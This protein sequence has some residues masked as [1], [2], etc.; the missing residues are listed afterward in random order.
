MKAKRASIAALALLVASAA[1]SGSAQ[2]FAQTC[3]QVDP[4]T[5][6]TIVVIGDTQD[7]ADYE[8]KEN[9]QF[10][11]APWL[12]SMI[13]WILANRQA[14]NIDFVLQVGDLTE[15]GWWLP[16]SPTCLGDCG[17]PGCHCPAE[18]AEEWN[19]ITTQFQ[20]L[21]SAHVPFALVPGNHDNIR[22]GGGPLDGPGFSDYYAPSRLAGLSGYLESKTSAASGCTATAWQ[23]ALG[24]EPVIVLALP[25]SDVNPP[26]ETRPDG[27]QAVA[28]CPAVD[29][30]IDDWAN[31]LIER[32][33]HVRKQA[34]LLHHRLIDE[35][36]GLRP[37]WVN[38]ISRRPERY[39][40]GISGHFS[41]AVFPFSPEV[42]SQTG[43]D[44]WVFAPRIDWQDVPLPGL[45]QPT[46]ASTFAVLRFHVRGGRPDQLEARVWSEYFHVANGAA[47]DLDGD[48]KQDTAD[49]GVALVD[50]PIRQDRDMDGD[51][52]VDDLDLCP[53][54]AGASALDSDADGRGNACECGDQ[55]SD[56]RNTVADLVAINTAIFNPG[57]VTW[58]C[59]ANGDGLCSVSDIIA[60]NAEIFSPSNTS[61]CV[62]QPYPGP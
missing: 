38:T 27:S 48:G 17:A 54:W 23:F 52:T 13:D 51:G 10:P 53:W 18:V 28:R 50:Y 7:V 62:R 14:E 24:P 5:C 1:R 44:L 21:E 12:A 15:H 30:E 61:T 41:P 31:A 56:G 3:D 42:D 33:E 8:T 39:I 47:P 26:S 37:K 19:V 2:P 57:A 49:D 59:D 36:W 22:D 9:G 58:R 25:D 11:R 29:P 43:A 34:I 20:R 32:P 4:E 45:E 60:A 46:A 55:N 6:R 40:A 35:N 16:M